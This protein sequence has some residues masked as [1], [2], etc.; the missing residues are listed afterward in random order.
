[1]KRRW[2]IGI[3]ITLL[4]LALRWPWAM[5]SR[6]VRWD[7][8]DMLI[9]A[10]HLLRGDGYQVFGVPEL[11]WPP[12]APALAAVSLALGVPIDKALGVWHMIAGA[13]ICGLLYGL[14]REVTEDER[15]AVIAG[16]LAA[17][18]PLLAVWP[19]YWGSMTESI[20][21][22]LLMAGFWAMWRW[23][24]GGGWEAA[25]AAGLAFGTS[26]LARPEA[27]GW[28]GVFLLVALGM[29]FWR[30]RGWRSLALY[31]LATLLV[32]APYVGYLYQ[33]TGR[34]ML[35]G[36]LGITL[37]LSV[38]ITELGGQGNDFAAALDSTGKEI[39]WLSPERF[40]IGVLDIVRS[41]PIGTLRRIRRNV[42]RLWTIL[43][44]PVLGPVLVGLI[45]LGL[46]SRPWDR[47]R[48]IG[49]GFWVATLLPLAMFPFFHVQPRFLVPL[50]PVALVW[51]ARGTV[52]LARWADDTFRG[53][54]TARSRQT[55]WLIILVAL[56][57]V[58][59]WWGQV[60]AARTGQAS[61][62]PSHQAAGLWLAEHTD[63]GDPVV[64]RN[65][66]VGLYADR[67]LVAFPDASWEEVL[68]YIRARKARYLVVDDWE[69]TRLRPQ[70]R[71]LL[72]PAQAPPEL[73]HLVT[74]EDGRRTTLI[75]RLRDGK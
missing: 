70:L 35:S 57:L 56:L 22:A 16:L 30:R 63:P 9:L 38:Q 23:F 67:P 37:A 2:A 8:P 13:I 39:M 45:A 60:L 52:Y 31:V 1:M 58:G 7:E 17:F 11:T 34:L 46:W 49:E 72:D 73:E 69:I 10:R 64:S 33:H 43:F 25:S 41:D 27:L 47:R 21:L 53:L 59:Q 55:E 36:K 14:S 66:E 48:W 42:R 26:Y 62:A 32:V 50:M 28:W 61:L 20:F 54:L 12:L 4:A 51:A 3:A 65:S 75:Y 71:F 68:A 24:H 19:L 5:Q 44:D 15:I 74:F 18:S 40:D 29:A 6:T